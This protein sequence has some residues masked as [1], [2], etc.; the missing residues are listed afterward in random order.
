M[1]LP[2]LMTEGQRPHQPVLSCTVRKHANARAFERHQHAN[3]HAFVLGPGQRDDGADSIV[4]GNSGARGDVHHGR[5][6]A[7]DAKG[8]ADDIIC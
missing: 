4:G 6:G 2:L 8:N 7:D 5:R 1:P 3:V